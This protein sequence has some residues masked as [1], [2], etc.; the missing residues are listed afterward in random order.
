MDVV[1]FRDVD[2]L[3]VLRKGKLAQDLDPVQS[4]F[5]AQLPV[6]EKYPDKV[7]IHVLCAEF[8]AD[9]LAML[10]LRQ[11]HDPRVA[12]A[13]LFGNLVEME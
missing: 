6:T 5:V 8:V 4:T 9:Q 7:I 11:T 2:P 3:D 1:A 13:I 12:G 10:I